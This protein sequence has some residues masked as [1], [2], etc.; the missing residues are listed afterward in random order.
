MKYSFDKP[1]ES[2]RLE[3][4]LKAKINTKIIHDNYYDVLRLAHSIRVGKVPTSR[5]M[6]K[7]GSYSRQNSLSFALK[8]MNKLDEGMLSYVSPL[9]WEHMNLYGHYSFDKR[10]VT[11]LMS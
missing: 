2:S 6:G 10:R 4:I 1:S 9:N 3:R 5:I 8:E 7:L 11:T